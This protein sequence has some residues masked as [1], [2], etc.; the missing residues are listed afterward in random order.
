MRIPILGSTT[1]GPSGACVSAPGSKTTVVPPPGR[2]ESSH[3][4]SIR[5]SGPS[6]KT[7]LTENRTGWTHSNSRSSHSVAIP[8]KSEGPTSELQS[9]CNLVCRL[10]LEK[11]KKKKIKNINDNNLN[12]Q[13]RTHS[14]TSVRLCYWCVQ[15][16]VDLM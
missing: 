15:S 11:K 4:R 13:S 16:I 8:R 2:P 9:P 5:A 10:L 12:P 1:G 3:D 7:R 6:V 14:D